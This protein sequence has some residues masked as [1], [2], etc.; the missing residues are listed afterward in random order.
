MSKG[1]RSI[2]KKLSKKKKRGV[3]K[4]IFLGI[5]LILLVVG[6]VVGYRIHKNGGGL[7]GLLATAVGHDENTLKN[8]PKIY[9]VLLGQSENLTDTIMIA[10]YDPKEQQAS[11]LSIPRDT[12][13]GVNKANAGGFDKINAV[14][15]TGAQNVLKELNELTGL[16]LKYY[17]KV[18]TEAFKV[19]VDKI[20]GVEFDVPIDMK[21]DSARQDLHINLKAGLQKL[22][23]DKAEQLVRFRHNN[24]GTTYS[25]EYGMEDL[26]RMRTQR[27]FL[28]A[29]AKQTLKVERIFQINEFI[30]IANKY[31]E[32][33]LDFDTIKDYVP[34][35]VEFD[36]AKLKTEQLPGTSEQA[37]NTGTWIYSANEVELKK[38][39]DDLFINPNKLDEKDKQ[40][41][42]T[43]DTSKIDKTNL[44]IEVLNGTS[45]NTKL[46]K[47]VAQLESAGYNISKTGN[48]TETENTTIITRGEVPDLVQEDIKQILGTQTVSNGGNATINITIIIGRDY[49]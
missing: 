32:T 40:H 48:T 46:E 9:C 42:S 30:D 25:Y 13:I 6:G 37:A 35:I 29:L 38:I 36:M 19:L 39:I 45:S 22:D 14:Y 28:K 33:N 1:K 24:D 49:E 8:L 17:L 43:V 20:G 7:K 3:G 27:E 26:G 11:I 23:G 10:E 2:D 16:D 21:Y 41:N 34:Y 31:V 44:K 18:D 12:F 4:K 47:V 15:Q 5:L